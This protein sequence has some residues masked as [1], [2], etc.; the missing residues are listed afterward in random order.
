[1]HT[2]VLLSIRQGVVF[3]E[4]FDIATVFVVTFQMLAQIAINDGLA[5][6]FRRD[7][8]R[9]LGGSADE[10]V[11]TGG[12]VRLRTEHDFEATFVA[13]PSA[14][15]FRGDDIMTGGFGYRL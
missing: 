7:H 15:D 4:K 8:E 3:L 1:M 14:A 2:L 10:I 11:R 5:T 12:L 13:L 6:N 9:C